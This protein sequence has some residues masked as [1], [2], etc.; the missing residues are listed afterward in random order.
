MALDLFDTSLIPRVSGINS[1]TSPLD[2]NSTNFPFSD[3]TGA[4]SYGSSLTPSVLR[5]KYLITIVQHNESSNKLPI[6]VQA[7]M[8]DSLNFSLNSQWHAP[9]VEG[10]IKDPNLKEA[11]SVLGIK[12]TTQALTANYWTGSSNLEIGLELIFYAESS[13]TDVQ[14]PIRNL[15]KLERPTKNSYSYLSSPGP[16]LNLSQSASNLYDAIS[17]NNNNTLTPSSKPP[18]INDPNTLQQLSQNVNAAIKYDNTISIQI[19]NFLYFSDIII[20]SVTPDFK[21][22]LDTSGVPMHA[23]VSIKFITHVTP[24][25]EDFDQIFINSTNNNYSNDPFSSNLSKNLSF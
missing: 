7:Y 22:V 2:F 9:F 16:S 8:P 18:N 12:A 23:R 11:A 20:T 15:I 21:M 24:T 19:G 1:N 10:I 25:A 13:Y 5:T 14:E 3:N 6:T 4:Q 17:N